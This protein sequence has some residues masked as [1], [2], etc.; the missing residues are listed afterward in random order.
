M[1][2]FRI[3]SLEWR[4]FRMEV[5]GKRYH[6]SGGIG[7]GDI[8]LTVSNSECE[9]LYTL[10]FSGKGD[11]TFITG[12]DG[13]DI[14]RENFGDFASRYKDHIEWMARHFSPEVCRKIGELF[15]LG[16]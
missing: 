15:T 7:D 1:E 13:A 8:Y 10:C 2:D 16:F 4:P 9:C 11:G 3:K 14:T 12:N 6:V 5:G